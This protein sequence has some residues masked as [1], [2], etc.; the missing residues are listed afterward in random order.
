MPAPMP[1]GGASEPGSS[2]AT[3]QPQDREPPIAE[4]PNRLA[5]SA[6]T[7]EYLRLSEQE[8]E[9]HQLLVQGLEAE[10]ERLDADLAGEVGTTR[11]ALNQEVEELRAAAESE[12]E[13]IISEARRQAWKILAEAT[14]EA[15]RRQRDARREAE[16]LL[17]DAAERSAHLV[18]SVQADVERR[19]EWSRAQANVILSRARCAATTFED[20]HAAREPAVSTVGSL[21]SRDPEVSVSRSE[22]SGS[23]ATRGTA[24]STGRLR[25]LRRPRRQSAPSL[26]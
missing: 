19:L 13:R 9:R 18:A 14:T 4:A 3:S 7:P 24:G 2:P 26:Q 21:A 6:G 5:A 8:I 12:C 16:A 10:R 22:E 23:A 1:Q 20:R 25:W 11:R 15:D 17:A